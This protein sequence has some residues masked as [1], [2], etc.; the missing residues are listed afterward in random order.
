[1]NKLFPKYL[2]PGSRGSAVKFLQQLLQAVTIDGVELSTDNLIADGDYGDNT[3]RLV[4]EL[5][6]M[7]EAPEDGHFGPDTRRALL[8]KTGID[9]DA[10]YATPGEDLTIIPKDLAQTTLAT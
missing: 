2:P 9:V 5:Q 3:T 8:K 6:G 4:K 1:M 10:I 7:L